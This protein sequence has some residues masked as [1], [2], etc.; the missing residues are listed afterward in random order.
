[1]KTIMEESNGTTT[2]T[3]LSWDIYNFLK[4]KYDKKFWM[5]LISVKDVEFH[6]YNTEYPFHTAVA[7]GK[8]A[9]ATSTVQNLCG[10]YEIS[11]MVK[12]S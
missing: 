2:S 1:M 10:S 9:A 7:K 8:F 6:N 3:I 5:V 4:D 12:N 11:S